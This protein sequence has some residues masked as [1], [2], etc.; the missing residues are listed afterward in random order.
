MAPIVVD[1]SV[2]IK[3]FDT[4]P[5]TAEAERI[6]L[7]YDQGTLTLRAPDLL[8]AEIGNIIWKKHTLLK[9]WT[10][11]DAQEALNKFQALTF[12]LTPTIR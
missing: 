6:L 11:A 2:V 9:R 5:Y 4:E 12:M 10:A 1:S 8:M 3:W 7:A